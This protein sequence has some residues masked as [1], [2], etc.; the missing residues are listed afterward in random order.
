[1]LLNKAACRP[2]TERTK[3]AYDGLFAASSSNR[4]K[5]LFLDKKHVKNYQNKL[6]LA[7]NLGIKNRKKE[8][9]EHVYGCAV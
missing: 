2:K 6:F 9:L 8:I 7:P 3:T 4:L 1:M 5:L